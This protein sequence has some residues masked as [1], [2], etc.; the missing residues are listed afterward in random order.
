VKLDS[1]LM[2]AIDEIV[3]PI[4]ERD[5]AKTVSPEKRP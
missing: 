5:P 4:T 2:K 1:D 3:E